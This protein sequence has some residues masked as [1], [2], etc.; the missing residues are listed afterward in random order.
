MDKKE[1]FSQK[2]LIV[3][4][5][6][7]AIGLLILLVGF[8]LNKTLS[9]YEFRS[10]LQLEE[11]RKSFDL[12]LQGNENQFLI[13]RDSLSRDFELQKIRAKKSWEELEREYLNK[14]QEIERQYVKDRE[15]LMRRDE[16][17][18]QERLLSLKNEFS[19]QLENLK[20]ERQLTN[21]WIN[22][23]I[24]KIAD[25]WEG[26]NEV[27]FE[28]EL[29]QDSLVQISSQFRSDMKKVNQT[30]NDSKE[31]AINRYQFTVAFID[32]ITNPSV[33]YRLPD[34]M[35]YKDL[36]IQRLRNNRK[37][38]LK[39]EEDFKSSIQIEL[40]DKIKAIENK[41]SSAENKINEERFWVGEEQRLVMIKFLE[42]ITG[43]LE[44]IPYASSLEELEELF[45]KIEDGRLDIYS[46]R[47]SLFER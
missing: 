43:F 34:D 10:N 11:F 19:F 37:K 41:L 38:L 46:Y 1:S 7:L 47:D 23:S 14:R 31:L 26:I 6:K 4:I 18:H 30:Y 42:L 20:L 21:R 17:S 3:V 39:I 16:Q 5:D 29:L 25:C 40:E 13:I 36:I 44:Q 24:E 32:S 35:K 33:I 28:S 9:S 22:N 15:D 45:Q 12:K 27:N 2:I 8:F